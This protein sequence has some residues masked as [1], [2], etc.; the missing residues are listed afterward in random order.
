M[1]TKECITVKKSLTRSTWHV[2][3]KGTVLGSYDTKREAKHVR[4][5]LIDQYVYTACG[6]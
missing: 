3:F 1:I 4:Q 2:M 5:S 6:D